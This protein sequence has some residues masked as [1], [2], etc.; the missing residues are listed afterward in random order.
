M[1]EQPSLTVAF[2][3]FLS[4][5]LPY[6][7][8]LFFTWLAQEICFILKV[9]SFSRPTNRSE[10]NC[11]QSFPRRIHASLAPDK[12]GPCQP[13]EGA[14]NRLHRGSATERTPCIIQSPSFTTLHFHLMT[15]YILTLVSIQLH[16]IREL[17]VPA[18]NLKMFFMQC[19]DKGVDGGG[20]EVGWGGGHLFSSIQRS[21]KCEPASYFESI[22]SKYRWFPAP[23]MHRTTEIPCHGVLQQYR[24]T[25]TQLIWWAFLPRPALNQTNWPGDQQRSIHI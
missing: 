9:I 22:N 19:G 25:P 8:C 18:C 11:P 17:S 1:V 10:Y 5:H 2:K 4:P 14:H 15:P 13:E 23:F 3:K 16:R 12:E 24:V 21:L 20:R 7:C 6:L